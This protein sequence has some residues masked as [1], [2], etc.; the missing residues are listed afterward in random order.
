MSRVL[1]G[2][3]LIT[4][5]AVFSAHTQT[6]ATPPQSAG[7][8]SDWEIAAV[9]R[10]IG[11]HAASLLPLL[12]RADAR[13]WVEKGAPETYAAQLQSCK[14]QAHALADDAN[15]L[16]LDP[17]TLSAALVV[18]FREQGLETMLG[19]VAEALRRYQSADAAQELIALTAQGGAAR[20]RIQRYVV[21]LAAEREKEYAVMDKEAQRCR[22]M[23][24]APA[25]TA[26][27]KKK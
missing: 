26:A 17:E 15:A 20:D 23:M 6:S 2:F 18:L 21:D 8:E 4:C 24:L 1:R 3:S 16:A 5:A 19:S 10:D 9:L 14:D 25:P 11:A 12:D 27:K 13:S 7:L 22:G